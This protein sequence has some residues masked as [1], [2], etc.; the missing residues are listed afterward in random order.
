MKEMMGKLT[1]N[2]EWA[3]SEPSRE[4][5]IRRFMKFRESTKRLQNAA[6]RGEYNFLATSQGWDVKPSGGPAPAVSVL[7]PISVKELQVRGITGC[8]SSC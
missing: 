3:A 4:D 5:I 7:V 8:L 2:L 1:G 6:G